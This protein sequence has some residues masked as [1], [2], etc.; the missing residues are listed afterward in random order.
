M[1]ELHVVVDPRPPVRVAQVDFVTVKPQSIVRLA[2]P[3]HQRRNG[4]GSALV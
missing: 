1:T 3:L 4:S 2:Q